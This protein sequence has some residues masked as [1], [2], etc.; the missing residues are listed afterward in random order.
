M[1]GRNPE[2]ASPASYSNNTIGHGATVLLGHFSQLG[3]VATDG[4]SMRWVDQGT[5]HAHCVISMQLFRETAF[6]YALHEPAPNRAW[7]VAHACA[8]CS[9]DLP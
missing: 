6:F 1:V 2:P 7:P 4:C 5:T 8:H 3:T 9:D